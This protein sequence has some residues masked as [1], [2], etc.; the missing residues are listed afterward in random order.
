MFKIALKPTYMVPVSGVLPGGHR[1][2]FEIECDR[3]TQAEIEE[4]SRG[5]DKGEII[6]ADICR[7]I[8]LGWKGVQDEDGEVEFSAAALNQMLGIYPMAKIMFDA[9]R[10]SLGEARIKN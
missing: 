4:I 2:N 5:N 6:F 10:D 1:F 7:R 8:I 3:L 9:W